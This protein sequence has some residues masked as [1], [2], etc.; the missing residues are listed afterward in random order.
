MVDEKELR[1]VI[2]TGYLMRHV[3]QE[4]YEKIRTS[5]LRFMR[6]DRQQIELLLENLYFHHMQERNCPWALGQKFPQYYL[7]TL[8]FLKIFFI[9]FISPTLK[10]NFLPLKI[11]IFLILSPLVSIPSSVPN[12]MHM[13]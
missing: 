5:D 13:S 12:H 8:N 2:K 1:K 6:R 10:I 7:K 9:F 4:G 3:T 11:F